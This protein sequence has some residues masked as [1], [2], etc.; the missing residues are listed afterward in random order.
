VFATT[1]S[2]SCRLR[3]I[4]LRCGDCVAPAGVVMYP[5]QTEL[6][7]GVDGVADQIAAGDGS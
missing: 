4:L 2:R 3:V 5:H 1:E 6:A 7:L